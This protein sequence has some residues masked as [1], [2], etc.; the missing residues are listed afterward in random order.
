MFSL[1]IIGKEYLTR[2]NLKSF[3]KQKAFSHDDR[4]YF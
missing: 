3:I 1:I 2:D 4:E